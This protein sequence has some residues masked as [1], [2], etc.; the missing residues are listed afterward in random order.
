VVL[1]IVEQAE[2]CI[3]ESHLFKQLQ[4]SSIKDV[5]ASSP[6]VLPLLQ[7]ATMLVS[8]SF[9]FP[10]ADHRRRFRTQRFSDLMSIVHLL[11]TDNNGEFL[12]PVV[13]GAAHFE[14]ADYITQE[15]CSR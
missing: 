13:D 1:D 4:G 8:I 6:G 2:T 15:S 3:F 10:N 9:V 5:M 14:W 12:L 7:A 11:K